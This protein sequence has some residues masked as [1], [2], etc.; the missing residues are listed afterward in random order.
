M[1]RLARFLR[2]VRRL[3]VSLMRYADLSSITSRRYDAVMGSA[4][5]MFR[6]WLRLSHSQNLHRR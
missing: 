2:F 6:L 5:M 1:V 4:G 3:R